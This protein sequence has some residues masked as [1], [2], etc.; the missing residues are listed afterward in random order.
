M[1]PARI[2]SS[3]SDGVSS[4]PIWCRAPRLPPPVKMRMPFSKAAPTC[5]DMAAC[6]RT[7]L[8]SWLPPIVTGPHVESAVRRRSYSGVTNPRRRDS[9]QEITRRHELHPN[10]VSTWERRCSIPRRMR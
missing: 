1:G 3:F 2:R 5:S 8:E 4:T 7:F 9:V 10:Q 6:L